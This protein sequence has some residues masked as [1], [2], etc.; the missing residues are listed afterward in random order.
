MKNFLIIF[1]VLLVHSQVLANNNQDSKIINSVSDQLETLQDLFESGV[2]SGY[3]Y[4]AE[5]R[6]I[7]NK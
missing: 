5:K 2:L 1:F 4:E 6:K 3:E 7:L